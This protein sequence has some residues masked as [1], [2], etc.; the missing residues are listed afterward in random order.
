MQNLSLAFSIV[1]FDQL[2][3]VQPNRTKGIHK[4]TLWMMMECTVEDLSV[5]TLTILELAARAEIQ[6]AL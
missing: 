2:V 6:K 4:H 1:S 3:I 5:R